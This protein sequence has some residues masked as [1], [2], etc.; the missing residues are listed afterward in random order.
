[1]QRAK[2][3]Q[4]DD[5]CIRDPNLYKCL[6]YKAENIKTASSIT[7]TVVIDSIYPYCHLCIK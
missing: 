6:S 7:L 1:M 5:Q 4:N 3:Q 2:K